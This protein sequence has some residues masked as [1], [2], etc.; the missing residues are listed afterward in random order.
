MSICYKKKPK[1]A[2]RAFRDGENK[3]QRP[4]N[5]C[6]KEAEGSEEVTP[7][8]RGKLPLVSFSQTHSNSLIIIRNL[9]TKREYEGGRKKYFTT[10]I[11]IS[12]RLFV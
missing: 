10:S 11:S 9:D 7:T 8:K 12:F 1:S 4:L 6:K 2:E 5:L 3:F